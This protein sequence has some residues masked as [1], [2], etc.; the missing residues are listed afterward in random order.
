MRI[1]PACPLVF[2][3]LGVEPAAIAIARIPEVLEDQQAVFI[4]GL[5]KFRSFRQGS[6]PDTDQVEVHIPVEADFRVIT[7]GAETEE[8]V[9]DDPV[10][11]FDDYRLTV[12]PVLT[13]KVT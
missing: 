5:V 10:T 6:A 1:L 12:H 8:L 11:A 7:F 9:G 13:D 3:F 2:F 4:A